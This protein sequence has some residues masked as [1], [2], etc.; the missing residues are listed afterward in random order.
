[1]KKTM[2][3]IFASVAVAAFLLGGSFGVTKLVKN[4]DKEVASIVTPN[5]DPGEGG[6]EVK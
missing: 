5:S 1:M 3:Q 6:R 4:Q 2:K